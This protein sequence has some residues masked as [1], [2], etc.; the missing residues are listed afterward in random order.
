MASDNF[1]HG[2][3]LAD[4]EIRC[5]REMRTAIRTLPLGAA[6]SQFVAVSTEIQRLAGQRWGKKDM[7]AFW[8]F[9]QTTLELHM[10]LLFEIWVFG[11]CEDV[12]QVDSFFFG[13]LAKLSASMQWNRAAVAVLQYMQPAAQ[14]PFLAL[15][16]DRLLFE[17]SLSLWAGLMG[18]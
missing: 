6:S 3:G 8:D 4:S 17:L 16:A 13:N 1:D 11:E 9:A 12:L 10:D 18:G 7:E 5:I 2:H 14:R 15:P